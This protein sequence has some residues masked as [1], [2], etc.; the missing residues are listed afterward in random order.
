MISR[1]FYN[2]TCTV[3]YKFLLLPI[4]RRK[5]SYSTCRGKSF[6]ILKEFFQAF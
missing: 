6:E 2:Y 1:V 5:K 4:V 3:E